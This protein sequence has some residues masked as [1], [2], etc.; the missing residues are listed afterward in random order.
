MKKGEWVAKRNGGCSYQM[1]LKKDWFLGYK[2][3]ERG[4]FLMENNMRAFN[5][6]PSVEFD[7]YT[8]IEYWKF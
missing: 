3:I 1:S 4:S 6:P 2:E 7:S 8:L 5:L